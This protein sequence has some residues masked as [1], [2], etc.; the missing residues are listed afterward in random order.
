MWT[1]YLESYSSVTQRQV[2]QKLRPEG[3][4]TKIVNAGGV[5]VTAMRSHAKK[6]GYY[7]AGNL[8][9]LGDNPANSRFREDPIGRVR[10]CSFSMEEQQ[11]LNLVEWGVLGVPQR[12]LKTVATGRLR[13]IRKQDGGNRLIFDGREGNKLLRGIERFGLSS[14]EYATDMIGRFEYGL[15]GDQINWFYQLPTGNWAMAMTVMIING[16]RSLMKVLSMGTSF[17]PLCGQTSMTILVLYMEDGEDNLGAPEGFTT[18]PCNFLLK[19]GGRVVVVVIIHIDNVYIWVDDEK[20]R[21]QWEQRLERNA[22]LLRAKWKYLKKVDVQETVTILGVEKGPGG[23]RPPPRVL[24]MEDRMTR[25]KIA[26][27]AGVAQW[28]CRVRQDKK[29][30]E[31]AIDISVSVSKEVSCGKSWDSQRDTSDLTGLPRLIEYVAREDWHQWKSLEWNGKEVWAMTDASQSVMWWVERGGREQFLL[32]SKTQCDLHIFFKELLA[33]ELLFQWVVNNFGKGTRVWLGVD[34]AAVVCVLRKGRTPT[35]R[36]QEI[37]FR[38]LEFELL[39]CAGWVPT[40][41]NAADDG[42]RRKRTRGEVRWD[43]VEQQWSPPTLPQGEMSLP[44]WDEK[45]EREFDWDNL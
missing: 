13:V 39:I 20:L 4:L 38:I 2:G 41:L 26:S 31:G 14:M 3:D 7:W 18:I 1:T 9:F 35:V 17:A 22:K 37:L 21:E 33:V 27:I 8:D 44:E 36:G 29:M 43:I 6:R 24:K 32:F 25:R 11:R 42:T 30:M 5:D 40:L 45:T 19:I 23:F 34:N 15:V 28:A 10:I 12:N 16:V